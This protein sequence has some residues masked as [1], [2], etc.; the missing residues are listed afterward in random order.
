LIWLIQYP[1]NA[2]HLIDEFQIETPDMF[3]DD[4]NKI[5]RID[6]Y[7]LLDSKYFTGKETVDYLF[8]YLDKNKMFNRFL[9]TGQTIEITPGNTEEVLY[10]L[11][12]RRDGQLKFERII[13]NY[14]NITDEEIGMIGD[15][16]RLTQTIPLYLTDNKV[17]VIG[18][19]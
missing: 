10:H 19:G 1:L 11:L 16:N 18:P 4:L 13:V 15:I 9:S 17:E 6:P 8:F 2:S 12:K 3:L 5:A 7:H 14:G